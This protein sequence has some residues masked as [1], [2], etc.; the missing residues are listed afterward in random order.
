MT[1]P[2]TDEHVRYGLEAVS[3][4]EQLPVE[5]AEDMEVASGMREAIKDRVKAVKSLLNPIIDAA[6]KAHKAG[7]GRRKE[8]IA[9]LDE[10]EQILNK[11]M[12]EWQVKEDKRLAAQ[13]KELD[14]A[15]ALEAAAQAEEDG[16]DALAE[17]IVGGEV[18]V[19]A[20][21]V[22]KSQTKGVSFVDKWTYEIED[23]NKIPRAYMIPDEK[24]IKAVVTA[25]KGRTQIPGVRVFATKGIKS[26]PKG[27]S[28]RPF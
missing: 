26:K 7:T 13:Q 2:D 10:A 6:N 12:V 8:I 15:A 17:A 28:K 18:A 3:Y 21:P 23:A 1:L 5:T 27:L 11:K 19:A 24:A 25:Q 22:E 14:D 20:A 16:N 4:A 9:P